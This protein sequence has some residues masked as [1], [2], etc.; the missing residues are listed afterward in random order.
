MKSFLNTLL[1]IS[2]CISA[3]PLIADDHDFQAQESVEHYLEFELP[4]SLSLSPRMSRGDD[5]IYASSKDVL[6]VGVKGRG[7]AVMLV[8]ESAETPF[9]SG[10]YR[11]TINSGNKKKLRFANKPGSYKYSIVD[12]SDKNGSEERPVLDP[13]IIIKN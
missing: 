8:I 7:N 5:T 10:K 2:I 1:F 6:V 13:V 9:L 4:A 3:Q 12:V 11:V